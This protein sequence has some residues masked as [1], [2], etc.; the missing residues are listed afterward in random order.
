[1]LEK[2]DMESGRQE[3]GGQNRKNEL[4]Q[5][6]LSEAFSLAF[7]KERCPVLLIWIYLLIQAHLIL[8]F[9]FVA[10]HRGCFFTNWKFVTTLPKRSL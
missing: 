9:H 6:F 4:P 10:L 2:S 5:T 7:L 8:L 3:I 1:M